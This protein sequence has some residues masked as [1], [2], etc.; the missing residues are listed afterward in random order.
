MVTAEYLEQK[1][2]NAKAGRE[3]L[4]SLY[5]LAPKVIRWAQEIAREQGSDSSE[6]TYAWGKVEEVLAII[7]HRQVQ[8]K[9]QTYL[10]NFCEEY[11]EAVQCRVYDV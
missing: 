2:T 5:N 1:I 6:S 10:D 8:Q 4:A 7:S 11:P 9:N 3:N